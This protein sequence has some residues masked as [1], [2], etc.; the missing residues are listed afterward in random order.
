VKRSVE[1]ERARL[2]AALTITSL[3]QDIFLV[4]ANLFAGLAN[5]CSAMAQAH[6][7]FS[8]TFLFL[9]RDQAN[10]YLDL[11]GITYASGKRDGGRPA[12]I[13]EGEE[14]DA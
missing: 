8:N 3:I 9:Y 14:E 2:V 5:V 10:K 4:G 6:T 11:T 7:N 12:E 1:R 13:E